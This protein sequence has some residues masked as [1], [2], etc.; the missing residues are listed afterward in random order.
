MNY[1]AEA[2]GDDP[3]RPPPVAR[4]AAARGRARRTRRAAGRET[5]GPRGFRQGVH[6]NVEPPGILAASPLLTPVVLTHLRL[7]STAWSMISQ[8]LPTRWSPSSTPPWLSGR[9]A[10]PPM[11]P[12]RSCSR[13]STAWRGR[14]L[15]AAVPFDDIFV[16]F[17]VARQ[18]SPSWPRSWADF[19]L[20]QRSPSGVP[21]GMRGPTCTFWAS[22]APFS[23]RWHSLHPH[24]ESACER[25]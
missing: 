1:T 22:L 4:L 7:P 20:L 23:L 24:S 9:S 5:T 12:G 8:C 15:R 3:R 13:M 17:A 25:E 10:A 14:R 19:S 2:R 21:T 6:L 11:Q 16:H 18:T